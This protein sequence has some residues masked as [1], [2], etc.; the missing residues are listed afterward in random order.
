M[1]LQLRYL[2]LLSSK[3]ILFFSSVQTSLKLSCIVNEN[4][5]ARLLY[6]KVYHKLLA[7]SQHSLDSTNERKKKNERKKEKNAKKIPEKAEEACFSGI[8][9]EEMPQVKISE[10]LRSSASIFSYRFTTRARRNIPILFF[11]SCPVLLFCEQSKFQKKKTAPDC[12]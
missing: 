5:R 2:P 6:H 10:F 9:A 4:Q 3:S 11:L 8:G 1:S 12:S 7:I